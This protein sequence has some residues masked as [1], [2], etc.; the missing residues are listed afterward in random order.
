MPGRAVALLAALAVAAAAG[1]AVVVACAA[2]SRE[3][4]ADAAPPEF[5][6]LDALVSPR[7]AYFAGR[8]VQLSFTVVAP[9]P[10]ALQIEVVRNKTD[11]PVRTIVP[12][13]AEPRVAQLVEWD[14]LTGR[15]E[16]APNGDYRMR[17]RGADGRVR[18]GGTFRLR[19][20][21]YP[22]R[23]RHADRGPIGTFGVA[24]SGGRIHQ[25]FDV[26]AA[27]GT[28]VVAARGG[29]VAR[30]GYDPVLY[31]NFVI[32]RGEKTRRDYWYSHLK[33]ATR[34]R[35]GDRVRTGQRIASIGDTG[36]AR[37][38]G[39]HLHFEIHSRGR[40]VDPAPELHAWDRWS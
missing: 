26:D 29:R 8:P 18:R 33:N 31:G 6:I 4:A 10:M 9:A 23:G 38:I 11:Q 28:P 16:V 35:V 15:G 32:V 13:P 14:G 20:H 36:N 25:G 39:C 19:S 12:P 2:D 1:G 40:P 27:C 21:H 17:I 34:L 5:R 3:P 30:A 37:T 22:I 24:R 7:H